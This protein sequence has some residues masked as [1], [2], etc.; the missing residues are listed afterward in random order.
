[1]LKKGR[2]QNEHKRKKRIIGKQGFDKRKEKSV[3]AG[4]E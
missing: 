4:R 2:M 3:F 1:M